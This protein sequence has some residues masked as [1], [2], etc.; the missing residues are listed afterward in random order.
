MNSIQNFVL[1]VFERES[2]D[3]IL[4]VSSMRHNASL[5]PHEYI[6]TAHA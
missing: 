1:N 4:F 2:A 6:G 3:A 5:L